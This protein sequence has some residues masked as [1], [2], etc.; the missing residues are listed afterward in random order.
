MIPFFLPVPQVLGGTT[1]GGTA[2]ITPDPT[3]SYFG[4]RLYY[5][6][7]GAAATTGQIASDILAIRVNLN[8][9]TQWQLTGA[10][11][12]AINAFRG[13]SPDAGEIPLWF[14][15]PYRKAQNVQ[16]FRTWGMVGIDNFTV[17]VDI[18][19]SAPT[20]VLTASRYW[21][22]IPSVMGE[23]RKFKPV[24]VPI[25]VAGD[26]TLTTLPRND[27]ILNLHCNTA[28]ITN[29]KVKLNSVEQYNIAPGRLHSLAKEYGMVPQSG[30]QH[31]SFDYRNRGALGVESLDP[32]LDSKGGVSF[33]YSVLLALDITLTTNAAT[34]FTMIR[35]LSGPRD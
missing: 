35:E 9:T 23:I 24:T 14:H 4:L 25:S 10:Q 2:T 21:T 3:G 6:R 8:G 29:M 11:L 27:R 7:G 5:T 26:N 20:P 32:F 18:S 31:L 13:I 33:P 16:D 19:G 15:E 28:I 22:P 1:A 17:E 30:W 12:Q 34:P